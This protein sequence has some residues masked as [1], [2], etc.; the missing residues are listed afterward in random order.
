MNK[1]HASTVSYQERIMAS[2]PY[3][4]GEPFKSA[5]AAKVCGGGVTAER[6]SQILQDM[7]RSDKLTRHSHGWWVAD[8]KRHSWLRRPFRTRRF[9][10]EGD[11]TPR[12]F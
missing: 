6:A 7:V 12:Y 3:R 4:S 11:Y 8:D 5:D 2:A 10:W 1:K 9:V